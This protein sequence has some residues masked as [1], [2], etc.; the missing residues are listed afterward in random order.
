MGG[1]DKGWIEF[2]GAP[3]I[4]HAI[5]RFGPQVDELLI[6]ANRNVERYAGLGYRVIEDL[7]PDF[8][9]P[10]AGLQAAFAT[11]RHT[12]LASC[13]CDC[14]RL[15]QDLVARLWQACA[16][17]GAVV[18]IARTAQDLHPVFAL[19]HRDARGALDDYLRSGGRR[20]RQW[21]RALPHVEV[22]FP[23]EA[24]FANL[25]APRDLH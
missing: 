4:E 13:P 14:P 19:M 5:Q 18:A 3:L 23:D 10:L 1:A 24:A 6:S 7:A 12:W 15:P 8:A 17:P 22:D 2:D 20:V 21:Y 11:A 9:G 25:N 16:A